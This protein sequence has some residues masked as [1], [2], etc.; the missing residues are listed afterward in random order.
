MDPSGTT[1]AVVLPTVD[2]P[3]E[4]QRGSIEPQTPP[5]VGGIGEV[6]YRFGSKPL[7]GFSA[8]SAYFPGGVQN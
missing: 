6:R 7:R 8:S 5:P 3:P 2:P 1:G 4:V